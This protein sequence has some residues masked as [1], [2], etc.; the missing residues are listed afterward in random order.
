M[1]SYGKTPLEMLHR[2]LQELNEE[3][4][5]KAGSTL[6]KIRHVEALIKASETPSAKTYAEFN[7]PWEAIELCLTAKPGKLTKNE[8]ASEIL[9]GGY[10]S[11]KPKRSRGLLNDSI[12]HHTK[13]GRIV[14]KD[15]L[16]WLVPKNDSNSNGER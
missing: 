14:I 11:P 4:E 6:E 2:Y 5:A 8:L 12:N 16:L 3:L 9:A 10:R 1:P 15:G 7:S 13:K